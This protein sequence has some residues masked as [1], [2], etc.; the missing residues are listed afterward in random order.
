MKSF[1]FWAL[2]GGGKRL[3]YQ[4]LSIFSELRNNTKETTPI[5]KF[6]RRK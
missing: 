1:L 6:E 4:L 3:M 5:I 2:K